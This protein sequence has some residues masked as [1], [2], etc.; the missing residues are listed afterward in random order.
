MR[1]DVSRSVLFLSVRIYLVL[2][3]TP[4]HDSGLQ[5]VRAL[6]LYI[7]DACVLLLLFGATYTETGII[8]EVESGSFSASASPLSF[9]LSLLRPCVWL[10]CRKKRHPTIASQ[11]HGAPLKF[12]C[13]SLHSSQPSCSSVYNS[14]IQHETLKAWL[15]ILLVLTPD[16]P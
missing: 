6:M 10:R 11:G 12:M 14:L 8:F 15:F 1:Y 9:S 3:C 7:C 5:T 16:C 13:A 4:T 2:K